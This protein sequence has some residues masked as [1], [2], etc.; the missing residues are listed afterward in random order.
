MSSYSRRSS[1]SQPGRPGRRRP[2]HC[3]VPHGA[4][5]EPRCHP[6]PHGRTS[7]SMSCSPWSTASRTAL[8]EPNYLPMRKRCTGRHHLHVVG[9][10]PPVGAVPQP[11]SATGAYGNDH[12]WYDHARK[13]RPR[14]QGAADVPAVGA[15][16][17]PVRPAPQV[18]GDDPPRRRAHPGQDLPRTPH[19]APLHAGH[20]RRD[21][22]RPRLLSWRAEPTGHRPPHS[23]HGHAGLAVH[24]GRLQTG[25]DE[26]K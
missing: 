18:P 10:T 12:R 7:R 17:R 19:H 20:P 1:L 11:T 9:G 3:E 23:G 21:P 22:R 6:R 24:H 26:S 2:S 8:P 25:D 16:G 15:K 5:D 14:R 4:L 13:R